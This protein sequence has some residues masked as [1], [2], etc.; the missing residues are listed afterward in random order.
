MLHTY[1]C[2]QTTLKLINF[3]RIH[4]KT[5]DVPYVTWGPISNQNNNLG[6]HHESEEWRTL[7]DP[8]LCE[9]NGILQ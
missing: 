7:I 9:D 6:R 4:G 8:L 1:T 3:H 5:S 2:T